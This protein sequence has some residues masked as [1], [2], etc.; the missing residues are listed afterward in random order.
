MVIYMS[1]MKKSIFSI[2]LS[3]LMTVGCNQVELDD[4]CYTDG[5]GRTFTASFE[6]SETRTYVEDGNLLRWNAGDQ[7]S[8][9]D[10]NDQNLQYEFDGET[11]DDSG[12]F[13]FIGTSDGSGND[14]SANYAVYPYASDV[15]ITGDGVITVTL[16]AQQNYAENS[17]GLCAN[18]MVAVTKDADDTFL[19]FKNA[20]GYLK[21]QLYGDDVT[22][23]SI[24]LTGNKNEK[25]AGKATV[26]PVYGEAPVVSMDADAVKTITLDCGDGVKIG[27]TEESATAFWIVVPPIDFE[28]GFTVTITNTLGMK[29]SKSTSNEILI[30]RNVIKPMEAF[31]VQIAK[32]LNDEIRYTASERARPY[33]DDEFG[34]KIDYNSFNYNTGEGV[35]KFKG[36]VTE[37]GYYAFYMCIE[38]KSIYIPSSVE[39]FGMMALYGC[40]NIRKIYCLGV[41]P[42]RGADRMFAGLPSDMMIYVPM[43]SVDKYKK[44][45]Y[46]SDYKSRIV[47]CNF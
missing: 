13:S 41:D 39:E 31:E 6:Q 44:A 46:W 26:T 4:P 22:V 3:A 15:K 36:D 37:I 10:C 30:E 40:R 18:T 1:L 19:K 11:G 35:I 7:I 34:A 5:S 2:F 38:L 16:P 32:I 14:L 17:F 27:T 25:L 8:L 29:F 42:P 9:F 21:L 33:Y 12:T 24:T 23:Q 43:E 47:G 20:C 45:W 28:S